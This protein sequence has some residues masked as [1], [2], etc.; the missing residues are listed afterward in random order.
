MSVAQLGS[1]MGTLFDEQATEGDGVNFD[2]FSGWA[3]IGAAVVDDAEFTNLC[4][5]RPRTVDCAPCIM[6]CAHA[7]ALHAYFV[8]HICFPF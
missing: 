6:L 3:D 2:E 8:L 7:R 4:A 5:S 1:V